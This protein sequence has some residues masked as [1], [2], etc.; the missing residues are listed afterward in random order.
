MRELFA[1]LREKVSTPDGDP[2]RLK[3]VKTP[4]WQGL[5]MAQGSVS[6]PRPVSRIRLVASEQDE[7]EQAA[8]HVGDGVNLG[9][10]MK[11]NKKTAR[12]LMGGFLSF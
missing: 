4:F 12:R 3:L 10:V 7:V 11:N 6:E 8:L 5:R 1:L 2:F 9:R